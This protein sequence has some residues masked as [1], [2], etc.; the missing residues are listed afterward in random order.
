MLTVLRKIMDKLIYNDKY[1]SLEKNMSD[2][3]IGSMKN[4]NVRNHLFMVYGIINDVIK[5]KKKCIDMQIYDLVQA[6]D[7]LWLEDCMNDLYDSLP[8]EER[9]DKLSLVYESNVKNLVEI[10]TPLGKSHRITIDTIV[11]QGGSWGPMECSNSTDKLGKILDERGEH[12]YSYKGLVKTL[13]FL[14]VDDLMGIAECGINSVGLN[15]FINT[16][17]EM[18]KLKFHTPDINGKSKCHV[19]HVGNQTIP[20]NQLKVHGTVMQHVE[21]DT[22]L[23]DI[24]SS[25]GTNH[26]NIE[27]EQTVAWG[28]F[29]K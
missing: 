20:C 24:I 11:Q 8:K 28:K 18:K 1:P 10:N 16:H 27:K 25:D 2:S 21:L 3:N 5:G 13:P 4:K 19:I 26:K 15:A 23:G 9:N 17:I 22:Y 29:R 7:A 14:M 6:F 12:T